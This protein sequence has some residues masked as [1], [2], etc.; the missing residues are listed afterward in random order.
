MKPLRTAI[1]GC[2]HIAKRHADILTALDEVRLV[3]FCDQ[4]RPAAEEFAQR[5]GPGEVFEDW[6]RMFEK[7][8]L[9]LVYICLPPFAHGD[10]VAQACRHGVNIF[11]EK[12]I[13][14]TSELARTMA[15]EV[16]KSNVKCQVGFM[17]RLGE[18]AEWLK[19][20][21]ADPDTAKAFMVARYSCN[22]L[23]SWWWRDK[24]KSGGQLVEQAIHLLDL[25]RYFLGEP[26]SVFSSQENLFHQ[27]AEGYTVE[28]ASA[29][30]IRFRNSSLAVVAA[31]NGAI[32]GR[33]DCD[34]RIV[35]PGLTA[36]FSDPNHA[37]LYSTASEWPSLTTIASEKNMYR[38]LALDLIEAIRTDRLPAV[39][40]EEGVL[41][42]ELA[43][44][45]ARSAE[46]AS[47]IQLAAT[48]ESAG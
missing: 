30:V 25:A 27:G 32:P 47:P 46:Q 2:G 37:T 44:A 6:G 22:S 18:A 13:A 1:L 40:I 21:I 7:L 10:E 14:L 41:S 39:P 26:E 31:T 42:L 20:H 3:G 34:W 33:W 28:D 12:P 11:L 17:Y 5:Y 16:R 9:D 4:Q 8:D 19:R 29:T 43:L 35:L 48:E 24:D 36:D 15:A 23:H 38:A 45:A